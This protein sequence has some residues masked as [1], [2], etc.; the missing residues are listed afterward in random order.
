MHS[1]ISTLLLAAMACLTQQS[2]KAEGDGR[3]PIE[4]AINQLP[5]IQY[6]VGSEV[7]VC[8]KE[9]AELSEKKGT[10]IRFVVKQGFESETAAIES[11]AEATELFVTQFATPQTCAVS[12]KITVGGASTQCSKSAAETARLINEA[13]NAVKVS[14]Q[15]GETKCDCPE[16]SKK[17]AA[18]LDQPVIYVVNGQKTTCPHRQRLNTARAKYRAAVEAVAKA[19]SATVR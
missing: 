10:P 14:Y 16:E 1:R 5:Q 12:G 2:A 17:L 18:A 7:T 4:T 6:R 15:V 9:A 8:R 19:E 13:I 11:L 3:C